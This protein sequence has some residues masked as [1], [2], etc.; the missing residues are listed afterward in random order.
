MDVKGYTRKDGTVVRPH[1]RSAPGT[2]TTAPSGPPISPRT[3]PPAGRVPYPPPTAP[4]PPQPPADPPAPPAAKPYTPVG[5]VYTLVPSAG[6]VLV[7][8]ADANTLNEYLTLAGFTSDSAKARAIGLVDA[9][10]VVV[11]REPVEVC[12]RNAVGDIVWVEVAAGPLAGKTL[13]TLNKHLIA[14]KL[15]GRVRK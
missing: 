7:F 9:G 6:G 15:A 12:D 5:P 8:A 14:A 1:T 10:K 2:R 3:T 13:T 11:S 4:P